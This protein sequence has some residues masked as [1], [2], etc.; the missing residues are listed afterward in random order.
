MPHNYVVTL[1]AA[2][3]AIYAHNCEADDR[4]GA[5]VSANKAVS[6]PGLKKDKYVIIDTQQVT[7][8]PTAYIKTET[9]AESIAESKK[10]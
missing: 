1:Q 7:V 9:F 5:G 6:V 8:A 10:D 4:R 3:G 2:D